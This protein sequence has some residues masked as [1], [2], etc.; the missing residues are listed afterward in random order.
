MLHDKHVVKM[1]LESAQIMSTVYARYGQ[2][3]PYRATHANHPS[4]RW[5]GDSWEHY[6]WLAAHA[7]ALC[8]EYTF[9]YGKVHASEKVIDQLYLRPVGL[10]AS[11]ISEPPQ[12]MPDE[13]KVDGDAVTAYRNYYLGAKV[14]QS[15]WTRRTV[16]T[17]VIQGEMKMAKKAPAPKVEVPVEEV[18]EKEVATPAAPRSRGPKGVAETAVITLIAPSNPKR[19][20]SKAF[21][22]FSHY[23]N[24]MTVGEYADAMSKSGIAEQATPNLVYDSK[25]GFIEIEGYEPPGGVVV[26]EVKPP[27]EPKAPKEPKTPKAKKEVVKPDPA[28]AKEI[29]AAAEEEVMD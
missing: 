14:A 8:A 11:W 28:K 15:K 7:K 4:V 20:G 3:A 25:H 12:C 2:P 21:I 16:P 29:E 24:G 22:A 1:I 27:K 26:K 17:F 5:A 13:Y 9:R 23:T 19:P 18:T 6:Q 10:T